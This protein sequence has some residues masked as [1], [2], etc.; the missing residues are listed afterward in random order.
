MYTIF[1]F[2]ASSVRGWN[3]DLK[4]LSRKDAEKATNRKYD[5]SAYRSLPLGNK[6]SVIICIAVEAEYSDCCT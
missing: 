1:R 3:F 5:S 2:S 4:R 6:R